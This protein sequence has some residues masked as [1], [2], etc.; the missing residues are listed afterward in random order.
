MEKGTVLIVDD[1][2]GLADV[3]ADLL[4]EAGHDVEIAINGRLGL[5]SL[6]TRPANLVLVD[7]MMPVMDGPEMVRLMREDPALAKIPVILM[8]ALPEAIADA[9]ALPVQAVLNKPFTFAV[10][11]A[12]IERLLAAGQT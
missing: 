1:E 3:V 5:H 7:V 11:M 9:S 2:F 8:T 10:L 4:R 6:Q 12:T